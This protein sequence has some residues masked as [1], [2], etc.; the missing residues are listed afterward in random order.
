MIYTE[1][2]DKI[3]LGSNIFDFPL[4]LSLPKVKYDSDKKKKFQKQ[5]SKKYLSNSP[6]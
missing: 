4:F 6:N 2:R 3:L 5:W 1:T